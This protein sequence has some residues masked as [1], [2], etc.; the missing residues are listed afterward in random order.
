MCLGLEEAKGEQ[1]ITETGITG[2]L[3]HLVDAR[4]QTQVLR[5]ARMLK[6]HFLGTTTMDFFLHLQLDTLKFD[7]FHKDSPLSPQ[8][9]NNQDHERHIYQLQCRNSVK[10]TAASSFQRA[11]FLDCPGAQGV[12]PWM[13]RFNTYQKMKSAQSP[14]QPMVKRICWGN[15]WQESCLPRKP[16]MR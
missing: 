9:T 8:M 10:L 5:A 3:T 6:S 12:R 11:S 4:K 7:L 14:S 13:F 15:L 2:I 16:R 1:W